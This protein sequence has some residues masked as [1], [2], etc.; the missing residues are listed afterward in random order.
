MKTLLTLIVVASMLGLSAVATVIAPPA[1][2]ELG[3]GVDID[4]VADLDGFYRCSLSVFDLRTDE[5]VFRHG[6]T[7]AADDANGLRFTHADGT[8]IDFDC[9]IDAGASEATYEIRGVRD[10]IQ[11]VSSVARVRLP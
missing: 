1:P 8:D 3:F 9:A 2:A 7:T 5:T 11:V 4:P 6:V 10:G